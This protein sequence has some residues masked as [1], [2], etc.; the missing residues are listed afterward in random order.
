MKKEQNVSAQ[1]PARACS[2]CLGS[3]L[4]Q[5]QLPRCLCHSMQGPG[6]L[7]AHLA[8]QLARPPHPLQLKLKAAQGGAVPP[9]AQPLQQPAAPASPS[10]G[11]ALEAQLPAPPSPSPSAASRRPFTRGCPQQQGQ[12]AQQEG[13]QWL[14][15]AAEAAL[16][17]APPGGSAGAREEEAQRP[18]ASSGSDWGATSASDGP[19]APSDSAGSS[20]AG[21]SLVGT[22]SGV[23]QPQTFS[24][25]QRPSSPQEAAADHPRCSTQQPPAEEAERAQQGAAWPQQEQQEQ[26]QRAAEQQRQALALLASLLREAE[27]AAARAA[28][29]VDAAAVRSAAASSLQAF[30]AALQ[31]RG[32]ETCS[33]PALFQPP[34]QLPAPAPQPAHPTQQW[35]QWLAPPPAA[36]PEVACPGLANHAPASSAFQPWRPAL[37]AG[38]W[39]SW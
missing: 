27:A 37:A 8:P 4:S 9:P 30:R 26:E 18:C 34:Q 15:E 16:C 6:P 28:P 3:S 24:S 21:S 10:S 11:K 17:A 31:E 5:A 2:L 36:A 33:C 19:T 13:L 22:P 1:P 32:V 25:P 23:C 39:G 20:R 12:R 29:G 7:R 38:G 35:Q 14:A